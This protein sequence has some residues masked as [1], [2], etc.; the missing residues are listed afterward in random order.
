MSEVHSAPLKEGSPLGFTLVRV[1]F[2]LEPEYSESE[3]FQ[4]T[5]RV[6]LHRKWG[7]E[8]AFEKQKARHGLKERGLEA[9]IP[10][11]DLDRVAS[12]TMASH[13]LVQWVTKN[14]G[15]NKAEALYADL[16]SRHF[17]L[18][19]KL[20]NREMLVTAASAVGADP[21]ETR[22]FLASNEGRAEITAAQ[23]ELA[24][25]GITGIPTILLGG[26]WQMP[27]GALGPAALVDAFRSIE[28]EGGATGSVFAEALGL[29]DHVMEETIAL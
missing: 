2:F 13:R 21:V 9:G 19:E 4:E 20:N 29:P 27:S 23:L 5:N 28:M 18:G 3:D 15:I 11:F 25:L 22:E 16:N 6:R 14:L 8:Q 24:S 17:E 10:R 12:S 26:K 1:P 7:G